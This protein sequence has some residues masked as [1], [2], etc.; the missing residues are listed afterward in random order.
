MA[1]S[2]PP[3]T[4]TRQAAKRQEAKRQEDWEQTSAVDQQPT[5]RPTS[6]QMEMTAAHRRV[7]D[8][9]PLG[10]PISEPAVEDW[11]RKTFHRIPEA[12]EVGVILDAMVRRDADQP[13]TE[14][15]TERVFLDR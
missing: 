6:E 15:P 11:F 3:S 14:S 1:K 10:Y 2:N 7:K 4:E 8:L 12:A 13:A 5:W 9:P